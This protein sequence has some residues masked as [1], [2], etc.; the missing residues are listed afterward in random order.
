[1]AFNSP[2]PCGDGWVIGVTSEKQN[3]GGLLRR[4]LGGVHAAKYS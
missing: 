1:M 3:K 4:G 2:D